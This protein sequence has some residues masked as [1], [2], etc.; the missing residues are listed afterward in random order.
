MFS[1]RMAAGIAG[2][3]IILG[4]C[5]SKPTEINSQASTAG[6]AQIDFS[7]RFGTGVETAARTC[8]AIKNASL[9]PGS[10]IT[11][12][13]PETPQNFV[14]A[15]ISSP[16][17]EMCPVSATVDGELTSYKISLPKSP[18]PL[19][20]L[21]PFIGYAGPPASAAFAMNNN[22]VEADLEGNHSAD[23]FR[24]CAAGNTIYLSV[25]H[26]R[27]LVGSRIWAGR[28]DDAGNTGAFPPC[29]PK[30]L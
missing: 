10:P 24:A 28:Y 11:L 12:I 9:A 6:P 29:D 5:A 17:S 19:G 15:Q 27:P 2:I 18:A 20:K 30:E 1:F 16:S 8:I 22:N 23:T 3:S 13:E 4:A 26:G 7:S 21:V 14:S 25:W